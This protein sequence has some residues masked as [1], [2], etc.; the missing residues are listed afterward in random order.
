MSYYIGL[1]TELVTAGLNGKASHTGKGCT[2]RSR[3]WLCN[4]EGNNQGQEL[5]C[6]LEQITELPYEVIARRYGAQGR[7]HN[8]L[9]GVLVVK[10]CVCVCG[11]PEWT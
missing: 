11:S 3:Q 2:E 8:T 5:Q 9:V 1:P 4:L 6:C 7:V 10:V